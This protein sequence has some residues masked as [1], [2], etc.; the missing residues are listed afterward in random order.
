MPDNSSN[1]T[2]NIWM[3]ALAILVILPIVA[4]YL[5]ASGARSGTEFSPDDFSRRSFGYSQMPWLNWVVHKKKYS[6]ISSPLDLVADGLITVRK[7]DKK[8]WHLTSD[9]GSAAVISHD[10]DARFLTNYL[11]LVDDRNDD[12]NNYWVAWNED[13]PRT[14]KIFWPFIAD[15]ARHEMYLRIPDIMKMAMDIK[16]DDP[17]NFLPR[18]QQRVAS[19]YLE[20]GSLDLELGRSER[21]YGRLVRAKQLSSAE[22]KENAER[23]IANCVSTLGSDFDKTEEPELVITIPPKEEPAEKSGKKEAEEKKDQEPTGDAE[24]SKADSVDEN[25]SSDSGDPEQESE[26][27]QSQSKD[28]E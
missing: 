21:A 25:Q 24:P 4:L 1:M 15:L 6:D 26:S 13:Y 10:C 5:Y 8:T 9:S 20:L 17:E 7:T 28:D 27:E 18:L 14:A 23:E 3:T 2:R 22:A 16:S 19:L 11:D 12:R